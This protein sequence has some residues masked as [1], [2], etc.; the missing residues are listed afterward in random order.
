M[1]LKLRWLL[2]VQSKKAGTFA[3]GSRK[4]F[5]T[6]LKYWAMLALACW[7]VGFYCCQLNRQLYQHQ[8]PFYD[9]LSYYEQL[10]RV[11]TLSREQG[12][13]AGFH[14]AS[15]VTTTV[16]LPFIIA[17]SIAPIVAPSR[18]VGSWIQTGL[19]FLFLISLHSYLTTMR[20]LRPS[21][22]MLGCLTFLGAGCL[23]FDNGGLSDFRMDLGLCL[24]FGITAC[25]FLSA[26]DQPTWWRF[27]LL[28]VAA[29]ACCLS[30]A[31]A[32][33][34]LL[35]A[36]SP[37]VLL[38]LLGCSFK[39]PLLFKVKILGY[40]FSCLI[41]L[42]VAGWFYFLNFDY[43]YF[44]YA[45]WNT[46]AN[47]GIP[48]RETMKH[49]K[50]VLRCLGDSLPAL[51]LAWGLGLAVVSKTT[52]PPNF[53]V[54]PAGKHRTWDWEILWIGIAPIAILMARRAGI[55]PFVGMPAVIGLI[56]F[57]LIPVLRR[58]EQHG[59]KNLHRYMWICLCLCLLVA[60]ARGSRRHQQRSNFDL[61]SAHHR[62]I[63]QIL[64]DNLP[65]GRTQICFGVVQLTELNTHSLYSTLL[66]DRPNADRHLNHVEIE[67]TEMTRAPIFGV[68]A[69][70]D[71][72]RVFGTTDE[73]KIT[74]LMQQA[75]LK[76]D[77]LV[78]PDAASAKS[79][80]DTYK[81]NIINRLLVPVREKVLAGA[82]QKIP[83]PVQVNSGQV[84]E[85]Y[86]NRAK[87]SAMDF[88]WS[89]D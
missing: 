72:Q 77:Y 58:L 29:G 28:G 56:L 78:I 17:A 69:V 1:S 5:V 82:W 43:L 34:Y 23:Y 61:M 7:L 11:M 30:R 46:D 36:L 25:L 80:A 49:P 88:N 65:S 18:A 76:I 22:A 89:T 16:S 38:D 75:E 87:A 40:L 52:T 47:A 9:S 32:P 10:F 35:A 48:W 50:M 59:S 62:L 33:I 86:R 3:D 44:Y 8:S 73:E 79:L 6:K 4:K 39:Q 84:V 24:T 19:L 37:I 26:R 66:F 31:T 54:Q 55:N 27:G 71:W 12:F 74:Y 15:F 41:V 14:E 20:G 2:Q 53:S 60:S 21:T 67:G 51:F 64:A 85:I 68:P 70:A 57:F 81:H 63:D 13:S 45:V 83:G 42:T